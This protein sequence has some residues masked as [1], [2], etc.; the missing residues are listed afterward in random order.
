MPR[1]V[2]EQRTVL[3]EVI[4]FGLC[5]RITLARGIDFLRVRVKVYFID[6]E[7]FVAQDIEL[8]GI[9]K[10]AILLADGRLNISEIG[11]RM[12]MEDNVIL[13]VYTDLNDKCLVYFSDF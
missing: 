12:A 4:Q 10:D 2:E 3:Q 1:V 6:N 7:V 8:K 5:Q 13:Q 11:E 9:Y